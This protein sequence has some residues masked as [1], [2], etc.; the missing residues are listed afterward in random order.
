M[1]QFSRTE[2][3]LGSQIMEKIKNANIAVFGLGAVGSFAVEALART[4]I[5][6]LHLIDFDR[7]DASNIN[8]QLLALN[9]TVGR[10][11]AVLAGERVKDINPECRITVKSSFINAESLEDLLMPEMD[12]VVDAIDGLNSKINLIAGARGMNIPVVSSM[13]AGGK[14]DISLIRAGDISETEVCPLARV[15]RRRL[16]RRGIYEGIRAVYSIEKPLNKQPFKPEDAVD[17]LPDHGR[18]RPPIGTVVWIPGVFG[19]TI[20]HEVIKLI[21]R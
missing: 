2:Q 13:G 18:Q 14:T 7:V 19:L 16:H 9:S 4:G 3:L 11:K 5:G 17:A 10:E 12:V 6:S 8:R 15:V 20:A 1:N 21:T